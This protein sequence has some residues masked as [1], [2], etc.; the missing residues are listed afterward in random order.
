MKVHSISLKIIKFS[1][2]LIAKPI[3]LLFLPDKVHMSMIR[4][5]HWIGSKRQS[6]KIMRIIF[7]GKRD[8]RLEQKFFGIDYRSPVGLAAGFDKNAEIIPV[9]SSLGFGFGVVG[10]V[11]AKSS[12]G[13]PKPW[14]YRLPKTQSLV[15]NSGFA[16]HGSEIIINRVKK[17]HSGTLYKFPISIS[18]AQT[19]SDEVIDEK[20]GINDYITTIKR[21]SGIRNIK[22]IEINISCPNIYGGKDFTEPDRLDRLLMAIDKIKI[23]K[24]IFIKFPADLSWKRAKALLDVMV[25]HHVDGVVLSNLAVNRTKIEL[26]ENLPNKTLGNL[27]GKPIRWLSNELI[28]LTYRNYG[29]K[30]MIIGAGGIFSAKDAYIKIKFGASLV[31]M[32]TGV[33]INGPQ[34]AA[35]INL[36]LLRLLEEDGYEN[37]NQAIGTDVLTYMKE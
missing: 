16:S 30:L 21:T 12:E 13:N 26:K 2:L 3:L 5:S 15:I 1:Y 4:F 37:I 19:N 17:Y 14:F 20:T 6:R 7:I 34:L 23:D 35:E 27:S 8:K 33:I 28:R 11:T 36:D 18:V 24:P 31:E 9:I 32:V 29:R 22:M 25:N 10:S